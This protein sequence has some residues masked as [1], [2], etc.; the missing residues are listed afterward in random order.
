MAKGARKA[1][2]NN[3]AS[4][5]SPG[6][7]QEGGV[8]AGGT[9]AITAALRQRISSQILAPGAK[10]RESELAE[11]FN[12]SRARVR[13]AFGVLEERGLIIRIPNRGA[14][15]SRLEPKQVFEIFD[16]REY[17]EALCARSAALNAPEGGWDDL[18]HRFAAPLADQPGRD[19]FQEYLEAI[20]ALR[21]RMIEFSGNQV[22]ATMLDLVYDKMQVVARRVVILPGRAARGLQMHRD[23]IDAFVKRDA[24]RA[25]SIKRQII[26]SAREDTRKYSDFIL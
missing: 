26:A 21:D 5:R 22:A 1:E 8:K 20:V 25:E 11:E 18:A 9:N 17:L 19:D 23:L 16:V 4:R 2:R 3:M 6:S 13:D 14:I 10:L 24:D 12:V 7:Q 15:V